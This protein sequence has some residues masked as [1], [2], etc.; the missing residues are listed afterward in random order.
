MFSWVKQSLCFARFTKET[1]IVV[2]LMLCNSLEAADAVTLSKHLIFSDQCQQ[3][4][5]ISQFRRFVT[6]HYLKTTECFSGVCGKKV[7]ETMPRERKMRCCRG[8]GWRREQ[9]GAES[10]AEGKQAARPT[11]PTSIRQKPWKLWHLGPYIASDGALH[12]REH[13]EMLW[14]WWGFPFEGQLSLIGEARRG[15]AVLS[16]THF[17]LSDVLRTHPAHHITF[18]SV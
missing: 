7:T 5:F 17:K 14:L 9:V 4:L 10:R 13:L 3:N 16:R 2:E 8:F 15:Q 11:S 1:F 6:L 12:I 18:P